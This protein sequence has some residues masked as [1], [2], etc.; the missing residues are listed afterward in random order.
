MDHGLLNAAKELLKVSDLIDL[1]VDGLIPHR[2]FGYDLNVRHS[3]SYTGGRFMGHLDFPR[4]IENGCNAAMWSITTN[5][6]KSKRRRWNSFLEKCFIILSRVCCKFVSRSVFVCV[7][8]NICIV[9][10]VYDDAY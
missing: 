6:F 1:H 2:L 9:Y 5:P 4:A 10:V 8:H 3:G 7:S